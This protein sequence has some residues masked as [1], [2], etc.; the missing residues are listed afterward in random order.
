[1]GRSGSVRCRWQLVVPAEATE[2]I[3]TLVVVYGWVMAPTGWP[4]A[5]LVWGYTLVSF[6]VASAVRSA[7]C[8]WSIIAWLGTRII[9]RASRAMSPDDHGASPGTRS[10]LLKMQ[11]VHPYPEGG[12]AVLASVPRPR[13]CRGGACA[14]YVHHFCG[15][16]AWM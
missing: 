11:D 10:D 16:R 8:G 6:M 15:S 14:R 13:A 12:S 9:L 4:L 5:L 7:P 2:L 3:G 1:M